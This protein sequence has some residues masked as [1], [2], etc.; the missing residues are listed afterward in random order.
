MFQIHFFKVSLVLEV[1]R[2]SVF[3][4]TEGRGERSRDRESG[5]HCVQN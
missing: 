5:N 3:I 1:E 4:K 2:Y